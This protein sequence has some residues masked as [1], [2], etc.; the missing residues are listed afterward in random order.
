MRGQEMIIGDRALW[1]ACSAAGLGVMVIVVLIMPLFPADSAGDIQ[2]YG[3]PVYAF[4]FA[5]LPL[6]L[7]PCSE[8]LMTRS[9]HGD[10]R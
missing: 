2:G 5:A 6:T 1:M 9:A 10:W 4:E 3:S 8:V 7:L